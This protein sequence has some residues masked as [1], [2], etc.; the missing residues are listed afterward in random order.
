MSC[1][2]ICSRKD[3]LKHEQVQAKLT[4]WRKFS[5]RCRCKKIF[6]MTNK[7]KQID[8]MKKIEEKKNEKK[9]RKNK[10][11]RNDR[12]IILK[13]TRLLWTIKIHCRCDQ[14]SNIQITSTTCKLSYL[15]ARKRACNCYQ[16]INMLLDT[17]RKNI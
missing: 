13:S 6:S 1:L 17:M 5:K 9:K 14:F 8:R 15:I 4:E 3:F 10:V 11:K 7:L 2:L 12:W 16:S